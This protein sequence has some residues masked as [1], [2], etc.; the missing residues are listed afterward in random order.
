MSALCI[1]D[2]RS[3]DLDTLVR[4]WRESFEYAL[5]ITDPNP[6]EDQVA[7]FETEVRPRNRVRLAKEAGR[8]VGFVASNAESVA[9]LHIRVGHHRRGLGRH[10]LDLAKSDSVGGLWLFTFARNTG[11]CAFYE[12]Q[13][14]HVVQ[15]GFEPTWQLEDVKYAWAK[16]GTMGTALIP[17]RHGACRI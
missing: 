6:L 7:Y 12:S 2:F 11:A 1:E 15:R 10:L 5:G 8:I 14:F 17:S 9:Q 13:G 3:S 16:P 4:M